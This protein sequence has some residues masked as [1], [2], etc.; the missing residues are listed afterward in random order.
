MNNNAKKEGEVMTK[1]LAALSLF[2][3]TK[4]IFASIPIIPVPV[5]VPVP[6]YIPAIE[7]RFAALNER[8]RIE[9]DEMVDYVLDPAAER[10]GEFDPYTFEIAVNRSAYL[11]VKVFLLD[12]LVSSIKVPVENVAFLPVGATV[13]G[14][15]TAEHVLVE[16]FSAIRYE[17]WKVF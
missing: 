16:D 13:F 17:C 11:T 14:T 7:C 1:K 5:P 9:F 12:E 10:I 2:F 6:A 8:N 3:F 15:N 4:A